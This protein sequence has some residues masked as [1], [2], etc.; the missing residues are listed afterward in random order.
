MMATDDRPTAGGVFLCSEHG[1]GCGVVFAAE[2]VA[3]WSEEASQAAGRQVEISKATLWSYMQKSKPGER[4]ADNPLPEAFRVGGPRSAL[5]WPGCKRDE[6]RRW[7]PDRPGI[8]FRTDLRRKPA[9]PPA[10]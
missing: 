8:G 1:T 2:V 9:P 5:V 3:M 4:Y 10:D 7:W 6:L